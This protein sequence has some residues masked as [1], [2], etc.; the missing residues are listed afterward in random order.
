LNGVDFVMWKFRSM[1][2]GADAQVAALHANQDAGNVVQFKLKDDPRI[3][4]LG[5][6]M[7]RWSID[8]L[9]QLFNVLAG[10]MSLVGPRPHPLYEVQRYTSSHNRRRFL[11]KPGITGLWQVSG[12]SDLS[13]EESMRLDLYYVENWSLLIDIQ[14]LLRTAKAVFHNDGGY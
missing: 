13:W 6:W 1:V 8:E 4:F 14:L 2:V 12:R 9:P 7:R 10:S 5:R 11:V 3:T